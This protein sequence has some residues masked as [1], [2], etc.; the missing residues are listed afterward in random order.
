RERGGC[1][2]C[3]GAGHS[4]CPKRD[5]LAHSHCHA[6]VLET[7]SGVLSLMLQGQIFQARVLSNAPQTAGYTS[8]RFIDVR[9]A[10]WPRNDVAVLERGQQFAE[11]P[12][13]ARHGQPALAQA[14]VEQA[15][16]YG[17]SLAF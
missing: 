12:Y 13:A 17:F 9:I 6:S 5:R 7:A 2:A 8:A 4:I 10:F 11:T 15:R 16:C 1:I 14:I 3:R